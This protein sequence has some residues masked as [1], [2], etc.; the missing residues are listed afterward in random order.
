LRKQKTNLILVLLPTIVNSFFAKVVK[1][2]E[3]HS[4]EYGYNI[5]LGTTYE[6]KEIEL[7]YINL[8]KSKL[9]DG[10]IFLDT[11]L[12]VD[13][14]VSL[15]KTHH[16]LQCS[17]YYPNINVPYVAIDNELAGYEVT[18]YLIK[19]GCQNILHFTVDN[20]STTTKER[21]L[22]YKKALNE[23]GLTFKEKN[24]LYGNYGF[25]TSYKI[26]DKKIKED[27]KFDGIF[28]ISDKMA[29]GCIKALNENEVVIPD[30]VKVVG[31]D[32]IDISYMTS[33]EITTISQPQYNLGKTAIKMLIDK[34]DGKKINIKTILE[35]KL[36]ERN[37]TKKG[38]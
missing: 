1:G 4:R 28:A 20:N 8:L 27:Y 31:F 23:F 36:I 18:K 3:D 14:I 29:A 12:G 17:E 24:I 2:M 32:N 25:N 10:I 7:S 34:I 5:M 26:L 37:S 6:Q 35:H 11:A 13:D 21:L 9:V 16:I 19:L 33:P 30:E 15:R 22:G 38:D